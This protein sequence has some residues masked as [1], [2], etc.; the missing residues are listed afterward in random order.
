MQADWISPDRAS[1][2]LQTGWIYLDVRTVKE[3]AGG[4]VPGAK[5]IWFGKWNGDNLVENPRFLQVVEANFPRE[6]KLIVSCHTGTKRAIQATE[7]L[8][9]TGFRNVLRMRGGFEAEK[10]A[11]HTIFPGWK[12]RGL[13]TT[14]ESPMEDQYEFLRAR[15][16]ISAAME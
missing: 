7:R 4:H 1:E 5:N 3:F 12:M 9:S 10:E 2:L 11:G 15:A 14:N 13:P 16:G 6:S 8:K